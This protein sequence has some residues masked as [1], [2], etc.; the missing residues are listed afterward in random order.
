MISALLEREL[1]EAATPLSA[2]APP[3]IARW[4]S[5][6]EKARANFDAKRSSIDATRDEVLAAI[7]A[8]QRALEANM[9]QRAAQA[10]GRARAEVLAEGDRLRETLDAE[11]R[12]AMALAQNELAGVYGNIQSEIQ[13]TLRETGATLAEKFGPELEELEQ[14]FYG[15]IVR[16]IFG[17]GPSILA[18]VQKT[19]SPYIALA[20]AISGY[21]ALFFALSQMLADLAYSADTNRPETNV[22]GKDWYF[23]RA[24]WSRLYVAAEQGARLPYYDR[25]FHFRSWTFTGSNP[26]TDDQNEKIRYNGFAGFRSREAQRALFSCLPEHTRHLVE[27]IARRLNW[28]HIA[29]IYDAPITYIRRWYCDP[30][31]HRNTYV[32]GV[33]GLP[34][35]DPDTG[36]ALRK[37]AGGIY[38]V[39]S[40]PCELIGLIPEVYPV[41]WLAPDAALTTDDGAKQ[42]LQVFEEERW[43]SPYHFSRGGATKPPP[44][45]PFLHAERGWGKLE[46]LYNDAMFFD[47]NTVLKLLPQPP[48]ESSFW[49]EIGMAFGD[50]FFGDVAKQSL[51]PHPPLLPETYKEIID[52]YAEW[53]AVESDTPYGGLSR[54]RMLE[55]SQRLDVQEAI[56]FAKAIR[57]GSDAATTE[58][59]A[60]I[61]RVGQAGAAATDVRRLGLLTTALRGGAK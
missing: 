37:A 25:F 38:G 1:L 18:D 39:T 8:R 2:L 24:R 19:L 4:R 9:R 54:Q 13:R 11:A 51:D 41:F 61:Q 27:A 14:W 45:S 56:A 28:S 20:G 50:L 40:I 42:V 5:E 32:R 44:G 10:E 21:L 29:E 48:P 53:F 33:D 31:Y 49:T 22:I 47:I 23:Q 55:V 16:P 15:T 34:A 57:A 35:I 12:R 17:D 36:L 46:R 58:A 60:L 3:R 52:Q 6:T 59:R 7:S 30:P 26:D 43:A